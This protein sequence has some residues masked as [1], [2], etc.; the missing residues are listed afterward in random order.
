MKFGLDLLESSK[1]GG[2]H[3]LQALAR[4]I[5]QCDLAL[6][7]VIHYLWRVHSQI[8]DGDARLY[9][10]VIDPGDLVGRVFSRPGVRLETADGLG[11]GRERTEHVLVA[12]ERCLSLAL[13]NVLNRALGSGNELLVHVRL[14][15]SEAGAD[16]SATLTIEVRDQG[17]GLPDDCRDADRGPGGG[18]RAAGSTGLGLY[19]AKTIIEDH[20]GSL[21]ADALASIDLDTGM[22]IELPLHRRG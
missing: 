12:D 17:R 11:D 3:S 21:H 15:A 13:A 14:K 1:Q 16:R 19:L 18:L 7:N 22:T 8:A 6:H 20:G 2:E 10:E 5:A 9:C 4:S